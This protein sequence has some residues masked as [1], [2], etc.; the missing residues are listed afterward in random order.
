MP[1]FQTKTLTISIDAPFTKVATDL[2]DP[3]THPEWAKEF[4]SGAAKRTESGEVHVSVPMMGGVVRFKIEADTKRGVLD[5]FLAPEGVDFGAPLPVR[6]IKNGD[7]VDVLWTLTRVPGTPDSAW[8]HGLA[9][10]EKELLALKAR[11]EG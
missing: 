3:A 9:S 5:L 2:A 1:I 6:L 4:F 7:G 11:H 8:E 10:M